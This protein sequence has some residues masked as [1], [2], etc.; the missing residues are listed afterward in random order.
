MMHVSY[1]RANTKKKRIHNTLSKKKLRVGNKS[2]KMRHSNCVDMSVSEWERKIQIEI[3]IVN[4][5]KMAERRQEKWLIWFGRSEWV[6]EEKKNKTKWMKSFEMIE[7]KWNEK[8]RLHRM[9]YVYIWEERAGISMM[10]T[11]LWQ[12]RRRWW[13]WWFNDSTSNESGCRINDGECEK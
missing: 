4:E 12:W 3:G 1:R 2:P 13:W 5:R 10:M 9:L 11:G 6:A 8:K 7:L